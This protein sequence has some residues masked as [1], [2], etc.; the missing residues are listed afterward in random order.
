MFQISQ[1]WAVAPIP[2]V[3]DI[4]LAYT[5]KTNCM[6]HES[7]KYSNNGYMDLHFLMK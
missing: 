7:K 4:S 2:C 5:G 3:T 1:N 6:L